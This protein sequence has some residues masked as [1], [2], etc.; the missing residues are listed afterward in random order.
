MNRRRCVPLAGAIAAAVAASAFSP[1]AVANVRV[2]Q[3][4]EQHY[5]QIKPDASTI[6]INNALFAAARKDCLA[7][8]RRL[9]ADGASLKARDRFGS[10]PLSRAAQAGHEE[11][12][13]LFLAHGAEVG[14]RNLDGSTP[15]F[16][17][18]EADNRS[19]VKLLI[20]HG[21]DVN[22]P[23][24]S[25]LPPVAAAAYLGNEPLV[26]LLL[27]NGADPNAVDATGKGAICYAGGRGFTGV[28]RV[29]LEHG[30]DVNARYGN[31]LTALM[32]AAGHA[33]EAGTSDIKELMTLLID[34][35]A[36]LDERDNRGRSAL[37]IAA[38]LGHTTAVDLLLARGADKALR[39]HDGKTAGDLV[40]DAGLKAKLAVR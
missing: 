14:A 11:M 10:V 34:R 30:V 4:Q 26:R 39:D 9:L 21:A 23:G 3:E 13:A 33:A 8:A 31:N 18:A 28:V 36:H 16:L 29:L 19:I 15:L 25:G 6:E 27:D 17:A 24:R 40:S 32:W 38:A 5:E 37:M 1:A 20:A 7:L 35:G 12:V 22:T 2:C